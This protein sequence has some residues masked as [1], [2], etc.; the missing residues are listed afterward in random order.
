M[1]WNMYFLIQQGH[2]AVYVSSYC[3]AREYIKTKKLK[4]DMLYTVDNKGKGGGDAKK[5]S[6]LR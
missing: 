2:D 3:A 1:V 4:K 6:D 5:V